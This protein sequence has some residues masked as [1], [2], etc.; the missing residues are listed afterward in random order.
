MEEGNGL[1]SRDYV[2][3][4]HKL[5]EII[6]SG[7]PRQRRSQLHAQIGSILERAGSQQL[8]EHAGELAF[9]FFQAR[10]LSKECNEKAVQYLL[11]AGDQARMMYAQK[12]A[13]GYYN[14]ALEI[15]KKQG[16]FERTARVN[17]KLGVTYHNAFEYE[18]AHQAFEQGFR[19]W[20][21]VSQFDNPALLPAP[22]PLRTNWPPISSIDPAF[23]MDLAG[24]ITWQLFSGLVAFSLDLEIIPDA[25]QKWQLYSA[26]REYVF[27]LR[28]NLQWSDGRPFTAYDFEFSGKRML[29]PATQSPLANLLF[30]IKGA[31]SYHLGEFT[32]PDSIGLRAID[33]ATLL[34]ELEKPASYFLQMLPN[35]LAVPRHCVESFGEKWTEPENLV[36]SGPFRMESWEKNA[37]I[38]LAKYPAYHGQFTGNV[39]QVELI[40]QPDPNANLERYASDKL[41]VLDLRVYPMSTYEKVIQQYLGEYFSFPIAS[42]NFIGFNVRQPPFQ[43]ERVRLAFALAI[44]KEMLSGVVQRGS[45]FPATGGLIPPGLPGHSPEIGLQYDPARAQE[46]LS[47]AGYLRGR[48]FPKVEAL[49]P[50]SQDD[51]LNDSLA[52][53][54]QEILGVEVVWRSVSPGLHL[55][56]EKTPPDIFLTSW[57]ADYPDP[58]N[59]LGV[60][61]FLRWTGWHDES[62]LRLLEETRMTA[63]QS[64]RM[65]VFERA[66]RFLVEKAVIVPISYH[67]QRYLLKPWVKR[68]PTS[69]VYFWFWKD[70]VIEPH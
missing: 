58:D 38:L 23:G 31:H 13:S 59:F 8:C 27:K 4:H 68:Y 64:K 56:L 2:F 1:L 40:L 60:N 47:Q 44:D 33:A 39:Q 63:D 50:L 54:W 61:H 6:Y 15:L 9:H 52:A 3:T 25:A 26:G 62:Y 21:K 30:D 18:L 19:L 69:A 70:V 43:D 36:T 45:V 11:Q 53:Q 29:A 42:L 66:D 41:D 32:D 20:Q 37:S 34:V 46:L 10:R 35:F 65:N 17:M 22:H 49:T 12:E 14:Q 28:N 67:R 5:Q 51:P 24:V 48:G 16:D 55:V 57:Y 7:L